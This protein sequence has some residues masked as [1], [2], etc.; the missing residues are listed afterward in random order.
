VGFSA[1]HRAEN[2]ADR[3]KDAA[4]FETARADAK[5]LT[6]ELSTMKASPKFAVSAGCA[7]AKTQA[8]RG[9]CAEVKAKMAEIRAA[10]GMME[11]GRPVSSDPQAITLARLS[12]F[13]TAQVSSLL[14]AAIAVV[15]ELVS[16]LGFFAVAHASPALMAPIISLE[17]AE[18]VKPDEQ[19][20]IAKAAAATLIGQVGQPA[21]MLIKK[22]ARK[23][24][25]VLH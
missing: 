11:A 25:P 3:V 8:L 22:R 4:C 23:R 19:A 6:E 21:E 2:G 16:S 12:G 24:T 14:A 7:D 20:K 5:R 13:S 17:P 15:M 1:L 9:F 10:K 18:P